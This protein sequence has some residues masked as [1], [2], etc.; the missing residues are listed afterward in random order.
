M[1]PN[2]AIFKDTLV[3]SEIDAKADKNLSFLNEENCFD[4]SEE[5]CDQS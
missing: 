3:E 4:I 5:A 2:C 1:L